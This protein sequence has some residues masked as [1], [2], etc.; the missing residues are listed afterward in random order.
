[1][2]YILCLIAVFL[3]SLSFTSAQV[4]PVGQME[5]PIEENF[6]SFKIVPAS[7]YG[8]VLYREKF[9]EELMGNKTWEIF[10]H[11]KNLK[12]LWNVSIET[13]YL[14][15]AIDHVYSK[16]QL[17][18]LYDGIKNFKRQLFVYQV[19]L[20][21]RNTSKI[22]F[23][24]FM[25]DLVNYFSCFNNSLIIGGM[26]QSKP[27]IV[28]YD[29]LKNRSVVL[30]GLFHKRSGIL[31]IDIAR[32]N[33]IF[34][35]LTSYKG[36][37][38]MSGVKLNSFD[39][40]GTS[41]EDLRIVTGKNS[42]ILNADALIINQDTRI[43]ANIYKHIRESTDTGLFLKGF[44]LQGTEKEV[45]YSFE[46]LY[47]KLDSIHLIEFDAGPEEF[48][49]LSDAGKFNWEIAD[50]HEFGHDNIILLE[51]WI[52]Q[53]V[54]ISPLQSK[55]LHEYKKGLIICVDDNLKIKWVNDMDLQ[56][57]VSD[58]PKK[59]IH[60]VPQDD[61]LRLY[62]FDRNL[63]YEQ[64]IRNSETIQPS[65]P[66]ELLHNRVRKNLVVNYDNHAASFDHW[67]EDY[68]LFSGLKSF[69]DSSNQ[70]IFFVEKVEYR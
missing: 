59:F 49:Y 9:D 63:L 23:E 30:S 13:D 7:E 6:S 28:F 21:N 39:E 27:A 52:S 14:F 58:K 12:A 16:G 2:K 45:Y 33:Q 38:G 22:S 32:E 70:E 15:N 34:T 18:I 26:E 67:F 46:Y 48:S 19:D 20:E 61:Y 60:I 44:P 69:G 64:K 10:F 36:V 47:N 51:S 11:N 1:V 8:F 5:I 62:F 42:D 55:V 68:F 40:F 56:N 4:N 66:L 57:V 65:T 53:K 50:M 17:Y 54:S 29:L 3:I 25:P 41:V 35:V 31:D 24:T 43:V 37:D